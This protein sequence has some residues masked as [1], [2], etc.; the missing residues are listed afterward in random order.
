[1]LHSIPSP[2][3]FPCRA[4]L[5]RDSFPPCGVCK[6][7]PRGTFWV[8]PSHIE[9]LETTS[10]TSGVSHGLYERSWRPAKSLSPF[11]ICLWGHSLQS[12]FFQEHLI[13]L[14]VLTEAFVEARPGFCIVQGIAHSF[15][16]AVYH[17]SPFW[18]H[19]RNHSAVSLLRR[20]SCACRWLL[21][22]LWQ[23]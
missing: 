14:Y 13:N 8:Y 2:L 9:A 22:L 11:N 3:L 18:N 15:E 7:Y 4:L 5:T 23:P 16:L 12:L 21:P 1:M 19:L 6:F 17:P 10:I 20:L